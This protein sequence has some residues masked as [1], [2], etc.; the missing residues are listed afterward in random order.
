LKAA[1]ATVMELEH[2]LTTLTDALAERGLDLE[3]VLEERKAERELMQSMGVEPD[4]SQGTK[5]ETPAKP[6][7]KKKAF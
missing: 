5:P 1:Q 4:T 2:N 7:P 3:T 6:V